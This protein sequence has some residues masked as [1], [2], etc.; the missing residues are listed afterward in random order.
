MSTKQKR[1]TEPKPPLS[2]IL[3]TAARPHTLTASLSPTLVGRALCRNAIVV[4]GD[5]ESSLFESLFIRWA[6]FCM[7]IQLATNV[8]NDYSDWVR[9]ADDD[10]RV[11]QARATQKGWL[12]PFQTASLAT[13]LAV[14]ALLDGLS[15]IWNL[16]E[17]TASSGSSFRTLVMVMIVATSVFN[18]FAYTAGPYPLGYIGLGNASIAYAGL[19]DL[20]VFLYFGLVATLTLPFL[21]LSCSSSS[22]SLSTTISSIDLSDWMQSN[23]MYAAQVGA[24]GT[25]IIVVNNLRDRH[26][27]VGANKRTMAVRMGA[28]FCRREYV[29]MVLISY[30][31]VLWDAYQLH[32][33]QRLLPLL[34]IPIARKEITAVYE[35][36]GA[37]LNPHVGG[38]AKLQFLF[39]IL[40]S[41]SMRISSTTNIP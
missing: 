13:F 7:L 12:S 26:T 29:F 19:G 35:K 31:M 10:K 11:G 25:N 8:H 30:A 39:C 24:L 20:F 3:W 9:G 27:D 18:A 23:F 33:W 15:L 40:L 34:T 32:Q 16:Q 28:S 37:A 5:E 2:K 6:G 41:L 36:D 38:A 4:H 17:A 14:L 1:K 22:S 21:Y